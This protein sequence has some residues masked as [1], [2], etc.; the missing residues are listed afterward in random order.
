MIKV[1]VWSL[2]WIAMSVMASRIW[3]KYVLSRHAES[4]GRDPEY[5]EFE[6]SQSA[7]SGMEEDWTNG[8]KQERKQFLAGFCVG[9]LLILLWP[10]VTPV[11]LW[12]GNKYPDEICEILGWDD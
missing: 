1:F 8:T 7:L 9:L 12:A 2:V 10:I 5:L 3:I 11:M 6:V 4:A